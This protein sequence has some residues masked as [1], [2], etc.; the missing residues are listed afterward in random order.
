[1]FYIIPPHTHASLNQSITSSNLCFPKEA[2]AHVVTKRALG[3]RNINRIA[4]VPA[5]RALL[6]SLCLCEVQQ[7]TQRNMPYARRPHHHHHHHRRQQGKCRKRSNVQKENKTQR[8]IIIIF[9]TTTSR[10]PRSDFKDYG[11][12]LNDESQTY[13]CSSLRITSWPHTH[14]HTHTV[15]RSLTHITRGGRQCSVPCINGSCARMTNSWPFIQMPRFRIIAP[16]SRRLTHSHARCRIH[17]S[18]GAD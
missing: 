6:S 10:R 12:V 7:K 16:S 5:F 15:P 8:I 1:M 2:P 17:A 3:L 18:R 11:F 9:H 14:T 13:A 4:F